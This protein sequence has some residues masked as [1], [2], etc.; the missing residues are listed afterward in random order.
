MKALF[1]SYFAP[2]F[3]IAI[4]YIIYAVGVFFYEKY[5]SKKVH[6][7]NFIEEKI[8]EIIINITNYD[9]DL[10]PGSRENDK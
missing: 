4:I 7:D 9:I 6:D 2:F 8:E 10:T 1:N 5:T 3:I